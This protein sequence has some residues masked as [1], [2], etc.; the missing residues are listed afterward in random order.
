VKRK[1]FRAV[2]YLTVIIAILGLSL[3]LAC[4]Q[5]PR[6]IVGPASQG[7]ITVRAGEDLQAAIDEAHYGDTGDFIVRSYKDVG[8]VDYAAGGSRYRGKGSDGKD[9]GVDIAALDASGV[10]SAKEGTATV[11]K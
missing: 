11:V 1:S 9:P 8:F 5:R 7:T 4:A 2:P 6:R 3:A 10:R